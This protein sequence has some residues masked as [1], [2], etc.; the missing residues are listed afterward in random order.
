MKVLITGPSPD[1]STQSALRALA[2]SA[3]EQGKAGTQVSLTVGDTTYTG[4]LTEYGGNVEFCIE[5]SEP[6]KAPATKRASAPKK[7]AAKKTARKRR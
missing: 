5:R 3:V 6:A 1:T 7:K 4:K 2:S